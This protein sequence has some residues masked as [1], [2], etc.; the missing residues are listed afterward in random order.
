[1]ATHYPNLTRRGLL[2]STAAALAT[3]AFAARHLSPSDKVNVAVIGAGGQGGVNMTKLTDQNI[4]AT[5]DVDYNAVWR[6]MLDKRSRLLPGR[7]ALRDAYDRAPPFSDYRKMF[8]T[9]KDIDAVLIATP[10]HHHAVAARM[11][12][13]R[14]I[15][16]Y[17][18]NPPT[19]TVV[20]CRRLLAMLKQNPGLTTQMAN[21]GHSA[22][23]GRSAPQRTRVRCSGK[24]K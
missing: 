12:M 16:A 10:D 2:G 14:G 3:S 23:T 11:A 13:E 6:G 17:L 21:P 22:D 9:Q 5:C 7:E 19:Y 20:E 4:V 8:D 18:Q 15:H 1:M 24:A